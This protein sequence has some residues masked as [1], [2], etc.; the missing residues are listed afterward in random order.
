MHAIHWFPSYIEK[1]LI[2]HDN[3]SAILISSMLTHRL[4]W[5]KSAPA[6]SGFFHWRVLIASLMSHK[7]KYQPC[8]QWVYRCFR[9]L[10]GTVG[11]RIKSAVLA[12]TD[13]LSTETAA[14]LCF[15]SYIDSFQMFHK[16]N[17]I[18]VIEDGKLLWVFAGA[19]LHKCCQSK[20][21]VQIVL[22]IDT[23]TCVL[24]THGIC[25]CTYGQP[26]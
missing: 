1:L 15:E 3:F 22:L 13:L 18:A 26:F 12:Y 23:V 2:W 8:H 10:R 5:Q 21:T 24:P 14:V 17:G 9:S 19:L 4:R 7:L 25:Y 16:S 11:I 6:W 20:L